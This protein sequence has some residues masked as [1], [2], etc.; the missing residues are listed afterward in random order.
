MSRIWMA[1]RTRGGGSLLADMAAHALA[2]QERHARAIAA[3]G[4]AL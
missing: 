1:Y 4:D 2:A 3:P